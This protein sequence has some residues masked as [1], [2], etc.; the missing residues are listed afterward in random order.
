[1]L[2]KTIL[3]VA[4]VVAS[5]GSVFGQ[6]SV[7]PIC[8][9]PTDAEKL[10]GFEIKLLIPKDTPVEQ[11]R[12]GDYVYWRIVFGQDKVHYQLNGF[13]G[14][15]AY[16]GEPSR[17]NIKASRKFT[18]RYWAHNKLRGVDA[19]G[20]FRSGKLWRDFGMFGEVVWYYKVS[21]EAAAYFDQLIATACFL[22]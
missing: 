4:I 22:N 18:R 8:S 7:V 14:L 11:G 13:S 2:F 5:I 15:Q 21:P 12:D 10:V 19:R 1:M 3:T 20:T 16:Y 9:K 6:R 17:E